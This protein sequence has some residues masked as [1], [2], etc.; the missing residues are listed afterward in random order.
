MHVVVVVVVVVVVGS[1]LREKLSYN[2]VW[3]IFCK[4]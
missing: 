2:Y 3:I 4:R 1:I